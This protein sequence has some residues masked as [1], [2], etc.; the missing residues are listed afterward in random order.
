M[1]G[2]PL[3]RVPTGGDWVRVA[4]HRAFQSLGA[5]W[6]SGPVRVVSSLDV[7]EMPDG[8]GESGPQWH[9]SVTT[10]GKRPKPHHLARALKSFGMADAEE[11]NH[12]PGAAR[13]FF[14]VCDP[15]RRVACECKATEVTVVEADG[16]R[17]TNPTP[18]SG[19]ACR[20]CEWAET[21]DTP[22][23]IHTAKENQ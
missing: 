19:E 9:V 10:K 11:D 6:Q 1:S 23:P 22:C 7:A 15:K 16:Y 8:S 18:E 14:L 2:L 5:I 13:H 17:W 3:A 4:E 21:H 20:G 12:H